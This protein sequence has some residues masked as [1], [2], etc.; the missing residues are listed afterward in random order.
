MKASDS[1]KVNEIIQAINKV[2]PNID[3]SFKE[4]EDEIELTTKIQKAGTV[5]RPR[6]VTAQQ[7]LGNLT[8]DN[9][10]TGEA[11]Q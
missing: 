5:G 3:T 2:V 4:Y 11:Q 1:N 8:G 7:P 10:G 9:A 6:K